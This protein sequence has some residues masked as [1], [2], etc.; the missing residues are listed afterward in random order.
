M[1]VCVTDEDTEA[2]ETLSNLTNY[3]TNKW[4]DGRFKHRSVC[5]RAFL[6][7]HHAASTFLHE[8]SNV[9]NTGLQDFKDNVSKETSELF[10]KFHFL[11]FWDIYHAKYTFNFYVSD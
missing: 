8:K 4:Q 5:S 2:Q 11:P 9:I 7:T 1:C 6:F 10:S 3:T